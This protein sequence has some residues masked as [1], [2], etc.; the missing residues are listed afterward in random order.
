MTAPIELDALDEDNAPAPPMTELQRIARDSLAASVRLCAAA[1]LALV[2]GPTHV[3]VWVPQKFRG[4]RFSR[5]ESFDLPQIT[6]RP[7]GRHA[8]RRHGTSAATNPAT[9]TQKG[10]TP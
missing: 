7:L 2:P 3:T 5:A 6:P 1:G 8:P 9:A 4:H 10:P